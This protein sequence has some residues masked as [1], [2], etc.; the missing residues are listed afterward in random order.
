[1]QQLCDRQKSIEIDHGV[2]RDLYACCWS[3]HPARNPQPGV[4]E[5]EDVEAVRMPRNDGYRQFLAVEGV[6]RVVDGDG[7]RRDGVF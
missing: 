7:L 1:M 6:E 4:G 5:R 2:R 3:E